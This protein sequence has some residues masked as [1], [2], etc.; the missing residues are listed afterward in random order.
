MAEEIFRATN[1]TVVPD[2]T[3]SLVAATDTSQRDALVTL[4]RPHMIDGERGRWEC[5]CGW[6]ENYGTGPAMQRHLADVLL[7]A[8]WSKAGESE[9]ESEAGCGSCVT[10]DPPG[11]FAMRMY[12]CATCGNKRCP[13]SVNCREWECSGSND[14]DQVRRRKSRSVGPWQEVE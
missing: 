12:V 9:V 13:A 8:G 6:I 4:L 5:A 1:E 2:A 7:A 14:P 3:E 11:R 10:C